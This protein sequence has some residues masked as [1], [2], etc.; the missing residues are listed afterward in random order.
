MTTALTEYLRMR[1]VQAEE[2]SHESAFTSIEEARALG[3]PA[4]EVLKAL[5]LDT[6]AGHA[7]LVVPASRRL[8]MRLVRE[9]VGDHHAHLATELELTSDL[10]GYELGAMPPLGSLI[11]APTY[12]DP[13]VFEHETVLV[14][15][16]TRTASVRVR[17]ADLFREEPISR[18]PLCAEPRTEDDK[19]LVG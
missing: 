3:V 11:G 16:G 1:G 2:V 15:A 19:E 18:V 12:V 10:F 6:R 7:L 13:G 8:D 9:A 14:A 5:V 17:T 4:D